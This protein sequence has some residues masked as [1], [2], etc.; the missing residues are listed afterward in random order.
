MVKQQILKTRDLIILA[1]ILFLAMV[2]GSLWDYPISQLL[3]NSQSAFG[4]F[5]AEFGELPVAYCLITAGM[6][7][8][9]GRN[10]ECKFI[11]AIHRVFGAMIIVYGAIA[12]AIMPRGYLPFPPTINIA[13]GAALSLVTIITTVKLFRNADYSIMLKV[14]F[15]FILSIVAQ[16]FIIE[17]AKFFW[18]RPRMRMI[19]ETPGAY[20][21]PWWTTGSEL[22]DK[23]VAAGV[24]KEWFASFPSGHTANGASAMMLALLPL[25]KPNWKCKQSLLFFIG[26]AWGLLVALSRIILGLH[27]V[28][29]TVVGFTVMLS[30]LL[31]FVQLVFKNKFTDIDS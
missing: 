7:F 25:L 17:I 6:L 30:A 26:A 12:M 11:G 13:I 29:D 2:V 20:F 22:K 21:T 4:A 3:Y 16:K 27:F 18:H 19:V 10:R 24:G 8:F 14:A 31:F 9:M 1:G 15:I 23:L 5:F 28:T